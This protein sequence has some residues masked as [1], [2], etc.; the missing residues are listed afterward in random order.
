MKTFSWYHKC[1]V[2]L[3]VSPASTCGLPASTSAR[4]KTVNNLGVGGDSS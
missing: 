2:D 1:A 4:Q 3:A